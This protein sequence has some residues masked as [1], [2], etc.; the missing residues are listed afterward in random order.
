MGFKNENNFIQWKATDVCMDF[1]CE[2]GENN[3]YEGFFAYYVKCDGCGQVYE[4]DS[5][6]KMKKVDDNNCPPLES[7]M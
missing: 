7:V 5:A 6:I 2:C 4:M 1:F 3:H